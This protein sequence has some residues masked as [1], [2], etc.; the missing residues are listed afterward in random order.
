MRRLPSCV[1]AS[2]IFLAGG[3]SVEA[4]MLYGSEAVRDGSNYSIEVFS[5]NTTTNVK[6]KLGS[7]LYTTDAGSTYINDFTP[8]TSNSLNVY[9]ANQNTIT[10]YGSTNGNASLAGKF[11]TFNVDTSSWSDIQSTSGE[12][13][14]FSNIPTTGWAERSDVTSNTSNISTNT[15]DISTNASNITTNKNNINNLGE[16]VANATALTAALTALPQAST[17]SKFSCG[18]GTGTYSSSYALSVGCASKVN[19]RVDV[20]FGGSYVGGGS[21]DYGNG[22]LD[23]VAAKAGFVFKLG[24]INKPTL[25]SMK[26]KKVMQSKIT[27]L[28]ASN[29]GL[30]AANE[31][32]QSQNKELQAKVDSFELEKAALVARLEKIEQIALSNKMDA[33]TA[34][35]FFNVSNLFSSMRSFLISIN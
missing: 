13:G 10:L 26:E 23:N 30:K 35:S 9:D 19:E 27:E 12:T 18:V 2:A 6:T 29:T 5:L 33:K 1:I 32:I 20:N 17:D 7:Y 4:E 15:S 8:S 21:K 31:K 11:I 34:F 25:I 24:K 22:S 28:S 14:P 16:G 3:A